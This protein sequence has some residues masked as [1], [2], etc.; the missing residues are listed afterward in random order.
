M[1]LQ[2]NHSSEQVRTC[3]ADALLCEVR[4]HDVSTERLLR[5]MLGAELGRAWGDIGHAHLQRMQLLAIHKAA[6]LNTGYEEGR[7]Y[8]RHEN[9]EQ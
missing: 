1:R 7:E 2:R 4:R 5:F 3:V 8:E 6:T 9:E